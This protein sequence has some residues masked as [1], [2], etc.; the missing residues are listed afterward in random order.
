MLLE[1]ALEQYDAFSLVWREDMEF[2]DSARQFEEKL[3]MTD[4]KSILIING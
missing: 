4:L 2:N 1:K 3:K